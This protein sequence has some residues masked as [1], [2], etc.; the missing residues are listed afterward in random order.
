MAIVFREYARSGL[1]WYLTELPVMM[2]YDLDARLA[3]ADQ[4]TLVIRGSRDPVAPRLWCQKLSAAAPDGRFRKYRTN[5]TSSNTAAPQTQPQ[6]CWPSSEKR[7]GTG[8][9]VIFRKTDSLGE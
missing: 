5:P 6:A 2:S 1:R 3:L 4:P 9:S 7:N 8:L